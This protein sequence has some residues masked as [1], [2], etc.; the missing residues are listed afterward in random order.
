M[1]CPMTQL[2]Y[3]NRIVDG[4]EL[5]GIRLP[6][7]LERAIRHKH[8]H[9][10]EGHPPLWLIWLDRLDGDGIRLHAVCNSKLMA[11]YGCYIILSQGEVNVER[12]PANHGFASSI[13]ENI[14]E[15]KFKAAAALL[16][17]HGPE[18]FTKEYGYK[19]NGD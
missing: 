12:I 15:A 18:Q 3:N 14:T 6:R 1:V 19:R 13:Q 5:D 2:Y 7:K 17:I 9:E 11:R 16:R 10:T 4:K 8:D